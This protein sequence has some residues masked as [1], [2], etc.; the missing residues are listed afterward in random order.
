MLNTYNKSFLIALVILN[1]CL[2]V[3]SFTLVKFA[4]NDADSYISIFIN[5]FYLL[6]LGFV[7]L[8]AVV[9]QLI[10]KRSELSKVYPVNSIVPVLILGVGVILFNE[11]ITANNVV[12]SIVLMSGIL[13]LIQEN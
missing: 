4:A 5:L 2:Q 13:L 7:A 9:W 3:A 8:R 11:P 1:I 12:G 10:L 6:A